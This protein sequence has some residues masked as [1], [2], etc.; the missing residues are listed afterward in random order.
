[1]HRAIRDIAGH[2]A[3]AAAM[4]FADHSDVG[5]GR[6]QAERQLERKRAQSS[7]LQ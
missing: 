7:F 1:M 2:H 5:L 6:L 3:I 4:S